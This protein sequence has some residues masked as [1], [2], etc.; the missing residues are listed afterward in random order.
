MS[1]KIFEC[2]LRLYPRRFRNQYAEAMR[3]VFR[4]RLG[5]ETGVAGR[6]RLWMDLAVDFAVSVPR[7]YRRRPQLTTVESGGY[8]MTEEALTAIVSAPIFERFRP[9]CFP[10]QPAF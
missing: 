1:E 2:L 10:S 3:Q 6:V 8:R 9:S 4:D 5:A 7:E